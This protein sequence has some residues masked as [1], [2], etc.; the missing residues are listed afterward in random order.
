MQC[1][2]LNLL[3]YYYSIIITR[4]SVLRLFPPTEKN[5]YQ[6]SG[7]IA[8]KIRE[9]KQYPRKFWLT[10]SDSRIYFLFLRENK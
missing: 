5:T 1:Y 3:W 4:S 2:L 7:I 10:D 6:C 9:K 8:E